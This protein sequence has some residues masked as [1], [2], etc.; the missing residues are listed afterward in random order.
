MHLDKELGSKTAAKS[1]LS[2][3]IFADV[4][5]LSVV[6]SSAP[7][8]YPIDARSSSSPFQ[9]LG[10]ERKACHLVLLDAKEMTD[11]MTAGTGCGD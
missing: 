9:V 6:I 5:S 4:S 1:H 11:S 7:C 3:P 2:R 8:F 10:K